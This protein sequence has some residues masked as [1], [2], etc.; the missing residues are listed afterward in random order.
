MHSS[1]KFCNRNSDP[2]PKKK[3]RHGAGR[4]GNVKSAGEIIETGKKE[5]AF[6]SFSFFFFAQRLGV[7]YLIS[8]FTCVARR[9][10]GPL[11]RLFCF[12]RLGAQEDAGDGQ[13]LYRWPSSYWTGATINKQYGPVITRGPGRFPVIISTRP[14]RRPNTHTRKEGPKN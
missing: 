3:D 9:R 13:I 11:P 2:P 1:G 10:V 6:F 4:R 8:F 12:A 14:T 7:G 5:A